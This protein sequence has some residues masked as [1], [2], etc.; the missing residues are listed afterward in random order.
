ME[1]RKMWPYRHARQSD[2]LEEG[3]KSTEAQRIFLLSARDDFSK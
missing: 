2:S 3:L 1:I